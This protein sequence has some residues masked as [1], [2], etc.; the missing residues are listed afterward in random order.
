MSEIIGN[1][2]L[3]NLQGDPRWAEMLRRMSLPLDSIE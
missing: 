3:V 1:R 2:F